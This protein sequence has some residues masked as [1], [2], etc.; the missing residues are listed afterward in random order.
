MRDYR[1]RE[2]TWILDN[3]SGSGTTLVEA[4]C[5]G[6]PS[7]GIDVSPLATLAARIKTSHLDVFRLQQTFEALMEN[8]G[9]QPMLDDSLL[10][11]K[12][13]LEKWFRPETV[14]QL[15]CLKS[16][17]LKL[18]KGSESSFLNLAFFAII[19]RVS[20]AYDGEVRPHVNITKAPKDV[21]PTFKKKY[22]DMV[23]RMSAFQNESSSDI[24]ALALNGDNRGL[25]EMMDWR[26]YPIG[27]VI[28]HPPYLNCFDY[29]PV[30]KLEYLWAEG[31]DEPGLEVEYAELRKRETRC[32]PAT[33]EQVFEKYFEDLGLAYRQIAELTDRGTRC[34]V[35]LGDCSIKG[36][37]VPVL[38]RFSEIMD[39]AGFDLERILLRSTHYG[40]GKYAYAHRADYHGEASKKRDGILIFKRR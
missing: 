22:I 11:P 1:P 2:G 39:S 38:D 29:F 30:Y 18:P 8:L 17:L 35:V 37:V 24:P 31:F 25:T 27:L 34:C 5:E 20:H 6:H 7:I 26:D 4:K 9:G 13:E 21:F 12:R 33:N 16:A 15:A 32:W 14:D 40:I 36:E 28:S 3:F 23:S 10:P 19:R